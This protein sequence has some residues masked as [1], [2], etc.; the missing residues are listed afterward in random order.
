MRALALTL[1]FAALAPIR[2]TTGS[3]PANQV[4]RNRDAI[5]KDLV[6]IGAA[7]RRNVEA[8]D[9]KAILALVPEAGLRCGGRVIP[10]AKVELDLRSASSWMHGALFGGPGYSAR[11]G[12]PASLAGFLRSTSEIAIVVTFQESGAAGPEGRPC[13]DF[14]A[15]GVV[16]PG[17]PFCFERRDDRW[18]LVDSLYPCG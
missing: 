12:A 7:L 2:P 3:E 15:E 18:W 10:R 14:R 6:R 17:L 9:L 4:D 1:F 8:G 11:P 13:I 5:A 16:T